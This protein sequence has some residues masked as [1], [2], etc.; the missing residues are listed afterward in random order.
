MLI[1]KTI[2]NQ[3]ILIWKKIRF[4]WVGLDVRRVW[5]SV[6]GVTFALRADLVLNQDVCST[7]THSSDSSGM[8]ACREA[9]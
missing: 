7:P 4:Y 9:L 8:D 3:F 6:D 1:S 5:S 2:Q